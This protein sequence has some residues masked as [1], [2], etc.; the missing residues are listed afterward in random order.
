MK[1]IIAI[2]GYK[3]SG[4]D[5]VASYLNY[6]LNTPSFMHTYWLGR[7]L[8]F[9]PVFHKWKI[10]R[11]AESL[12]K[13]LSII[14]NIDVS[15]FE[16]REFKEKYY[17]DFNTYTLINSNTDIPINIITD[18]AFNKEL[19]R[20]NISVALNYT[21]SIRQI[22][23]FFGTEFM[24]KYFGD[25]LWINATL[26]SKYNN[27]IIADQR[28]IVE[29]KAVSNS[30]CNTFII[31]IIRDGYT[32]GF[33]ASEKELEQLFNDK[34]YDILLENNGSLKDLFNKCK[35]IVYNNLI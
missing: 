23:Q 21:L 13:I 12:K 18:K 16:D 34:K 10:T 6:L 17:F 25:K 28:F 27:I 8:N 29:N 15:K 26:N 19:Q 9:Q 2:Q 31:H 7:F 32:A 4:K 3:S 33:H 14:I 35:N 20:N 11:Y 5:Q 24:R 1:N 22:L 30:K